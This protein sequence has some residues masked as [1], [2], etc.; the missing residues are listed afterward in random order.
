MQFKFC[1]RCSGELEEFLDHEIQRPRCTKCGFVFYQKS[2]P[3]VT[4]LIMKDDQVLLGKRQKDPS[5]GEW[6][7]LGGFLEAGEHPLDGVKR[8]MKEETGLELENLEFLGVF[9]D[10]YEYQDM[11]YDTL[12]MYYVCNAKP[13][14]MKAADDVGE[15]KWFPI[16]DLPKVIAFK[17]GRE[18]LEMLKQ[19]L[20]PN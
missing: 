8:E 2:Y 11:V 13:G 16:M 7:T 20:K 5:K 1:P 9:M 17:N 14:E 18:A 12:N 10:T 19:K 4:A 3:T 6:D 15:L